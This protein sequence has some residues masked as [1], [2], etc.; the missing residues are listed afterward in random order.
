MRVFLVLLL[1]GSAA[2][3]GCGG[4]ASALMSVLNTG[5]AMSAAGGAG[6]GNQPGGG[7]KGGN[8]AGAGG[9]AG[10]APGTGGS[11]GSPQGV[12]GQAGGPG[13]FVGTG[14]QTG[15]GGMP[16][17]GGT[18]SVPGGVRDRQTA[19]CTQV[20]GAGTCPV[21]DKYL[22]CLH[23]TCSAPLEDCYS[24]NMTTGQTSGP[25]SSYATCMMACPCNKERT[26]CEDKCLQEYVV[27]DYEC[28]QKANS[29]LS[30]LSLY[31]CQNVAICAGGTGGAKT[32][33]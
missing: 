4:D 17:L 14:G 30:C 22:A 28:A 8:A 18:V 16:G 10:Y 2:S 19:Q 32:K 23:G 6:G 13:G 27:T 1:A 24:V 12:G 25:C 9:A 7:G 31:G 29:L 33:P 21:S 3:S 20:S 5:G 15:S 26:V 11:A